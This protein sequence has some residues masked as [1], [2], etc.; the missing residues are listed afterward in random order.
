MRGRRHVGERGQ[1]LPLVAVI[2]VVAAGAAL[3]WP[4]SGPR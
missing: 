1:V 4:G 2:V 3:C